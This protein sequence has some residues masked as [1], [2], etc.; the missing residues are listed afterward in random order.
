[1]QIGTVMNGIDRRQGK[2]S[3]IRVIDIAHNR[4][5]PIGF[6]KGRGGSTSYGKS[7]CGTQ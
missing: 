6:G 5:T 7:M 3:A 2:I 4:V 1:M